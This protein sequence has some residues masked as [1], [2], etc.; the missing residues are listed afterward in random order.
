MCEGCASNSHSIT[1][2][3]VVLVEENSLVSVLFVVPLVFDFWSVWLCDADPDTRRLL[4]LT[5]PPPVVATFLAT[6]LP[7]Y[8]AML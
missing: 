6:L 5:L 7:A 4:T 1:V 2:A 3:V 8:S